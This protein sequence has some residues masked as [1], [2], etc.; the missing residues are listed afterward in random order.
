MSKKT[1][2][3]RGKAPLKDDVTQITP[4]E[5]PIE[6]KEV[7][8]QIVDPVAMVPIPAI[9]NLL[10]KAPSLSWKIDTT[11]IDK[12]FRK[13]Y[14]ELLRTLVIIFDLP[15]LVNQEAILTRKE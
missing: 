6:A 14:V 2:R 5:E 7:E 9:R 4:K 11:Y 1:R 8:E 3:R 12:E 13:A 10:L 15:Y